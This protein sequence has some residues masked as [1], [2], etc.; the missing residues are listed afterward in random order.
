MINE[1]LKSKLELLS[2]QLYVLEEHSEKFEVLNNSIFEIL[3][4]ANLLNTEIDLNVPIAKGDL[5]CKL[6]CNE[7][8]EIKLRSH[9]DDEIERHHITSSSPNSRFSKSPFLDF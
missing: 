6:F 5:E 1:D 8:G 2:K 4:E 9:I 3:K 7:F